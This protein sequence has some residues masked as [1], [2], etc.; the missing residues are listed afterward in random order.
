MKHSHDHK[1]T[2]LHDALSAIS[3][4]DHPGAIQAVFLASNRHYVYDTECVMFALILDMGQM[5]PAGY[6]N[7]S[8]SL[9]AGRKLLQLMGDAHDGRKLL[10]GGSFTTP[11]APAPA[12][13]AS[14]PVAAPAASASLSSSIIGSTNLSSP[15]LN[16][17]S[18]L[19]GY[20]G[21]TTDP[22][23]ISV[24]NGGCLGACSQ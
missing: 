2:L 20:S 16:A 14:V 5:S 24:Q 9:L 3:L 10:A 18:G 13:V 22:A 6:Y 17:V 4:L 12:P 1:S 15:S 23:S 11:S 7:Q 19:G 8:Q 21:L